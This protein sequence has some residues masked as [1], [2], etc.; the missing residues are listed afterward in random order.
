VALPIHFNVLIAEHNQFAHRPQTIGLACPLRQ[1]GVEAQYVLGIGAVQLR[2]IAILGDIHERVEQRI[3]LLAQA[4]HAL[5]H[6]L[7]AIG[8]IVHAHLL[9]PLLLHA[10]LR[11]EDLIRDRLSYRRVLCVVRTI[12]APF[13]HLYLEEA[14][15]RGVTDFGIVPVLN[16]FELLF[17]RPKLAPLRPAAL[18]PTDAD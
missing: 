2:K 8:A 17:T 11:L 14:Q 18:E 10:P 4:V 6:L 7:E 12:G 3:A 16:I 1:L 13:A 9:L 5:P 15:A